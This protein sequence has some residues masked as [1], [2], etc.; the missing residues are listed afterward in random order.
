MKKI[1][2]LIVAAG[3]IWGSC[4]VPPINEPIWLNKQNR[5]NEASFPLSFK[6]EGEAWEAIL[7]SSIQPILL[8][9][10]FR[11]GMLDLEFPQGTKIIAGPAN[12]VVYNGKKTF[13]YPIWIDLDSCRI[14]QVEFRSPKT[15]N[16]DSV[17]R[18][19]QLLYK[20]DEV[21]NLRKMNND[22]WFEEQEIELEEK[23]GVYQTK[24]EDPLKSFYVQSG[25]PVEIPFELIYIEGV[26]NRE[27]VAGP[28]VDKYGNLLADGT[29]VK[30]ELR[31]GSKTWLR[32]LYSKNGVA[33]MT[34]EKGL[35]RK[36]E[37]LAKVYQVQSKVIKI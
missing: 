17:L 22:A 12:L 24:L 32:E 30:V 18:H 31:N 1:L 37:A 35:F 21:G 13:Y 5:L 3:I 26:A 27:L 16:T 28:M 14:D 10:T 19:Q 6:I 15:V 4:S 33:K 9:G 25:S 29:L 23:A 2:Y 36:C 11:S 8:T 34:L 20:I 7:Y